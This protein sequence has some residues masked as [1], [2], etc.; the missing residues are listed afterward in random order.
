MPVENQPADPANQGGDPGAGGAGDQGTI[1]QPT[2]GGAG[3]GDDQGTGDGTMGGVQVPKDWGGRNFIEQWDQFHGTNEGAK[4]KTDADLIQALRNREIQASQRDELADGG[5]W[6]QENRDI[7]QQGLDLLRAQQSGQPA[8]PPPVKSEGELSSDEYYAYLRYQQQ[9]GTWNLPP[10]T[11]PGLLPRLIETDQKFRRNLFDLA[12]KKDTYENEL[13]EKV[14][15]KSREVSTQDTRVEQLHTILDE[16][17]DW[18]YINGDQ[19]MGYTE[20]GRRVQQNFDRYAKIGGVPIRQ[21][22]NDAMALAGVTRPAGSQSVT[23]PPARATHQ[24]AVGKG[25]SAAKQRSLDE[26][27]AKSVEAGDSITQTL[28]RV[29]KEFPEGTPE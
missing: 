16:N 25:G 18:L 13:L 20:A 8:T 29:A 10:N 6:L 21:L 22:F 27:I 9:D 5:R 7:V 14:L 4:Y 17:K 15:T 12:M 2:D 19:N 24:P 1:T 26:A 3:Q 28:E 23:V 11:P